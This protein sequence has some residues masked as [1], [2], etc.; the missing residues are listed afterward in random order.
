MEFRTIP[1][2]NYQNKNPQ[3]VARLEVF[4]FL[5]FSV[6][7]FFAIFPIQKLLFSSFLPDF[8]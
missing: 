6:M 4:D 1:L 7:S 3:K 5:N 2:S 8:T